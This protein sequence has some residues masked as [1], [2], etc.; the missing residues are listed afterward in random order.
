MDIISITKIVYS[1]DNLTYSIVY[2]K[3]N[4]VHHEDRVLSV[5]SFQV[6]EEVEGRVKEKGQVA[7]GKR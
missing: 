7:S 3:S 2:Y 4:S 1:N 6:K 5:S